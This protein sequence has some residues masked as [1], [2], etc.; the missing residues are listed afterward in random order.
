[1]SLSIQYTDLQA[2]H[3]IYWLVAIEFGFA[4]AFIVIHI[5][6]PNLPWGPFGPLFDLDREVSLPT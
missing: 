4:L 6:L 5:L 1:M 3:V 2:K